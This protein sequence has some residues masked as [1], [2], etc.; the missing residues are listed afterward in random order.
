[1]MASPCEIHWNEHR[2]RSSAL[3]HCGVHRD[4]QGSSGPCPIPVDGGQA[5]KYTGACCQGNAVPVSMALPVSPPELPGGLVTVWADLKV[6][7]H[8]DQ[9]HQ[10]QQGNSCFHDPYLHSPPGGDVVPAGVEGWLENPDSVL[11]IWTGCDN[12]V[13]L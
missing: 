13:D 8:K 4:G 10:G 11:I 1:M 2:I 5:L 7:D 9:D 12:E 3:R 6:L